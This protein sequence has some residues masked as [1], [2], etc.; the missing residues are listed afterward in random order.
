M[1]R[2]FTVAVVALTLTVAGCQGGKKPKAPDPELQLKSSDPAVRR[3]GIEELGRRF[4]TGRPNE[5][6]AQ[7]AALPANGIVVVNPNGER[8]FPPLTPNGEKSP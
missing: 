2:L 4:G 5:R 8:V 1:R 7:N 3:Q 6:P